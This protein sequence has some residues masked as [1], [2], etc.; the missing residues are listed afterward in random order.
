MVTKEQREIAMK[1]KGVLSN[2]GAAYFT[3]GKYNLAKEAL[4]RAFLVDP[5]SDYIHVY[6]VRTLLKLGKVK[7][8]KEFVD[9][10]EDNFG[11][12]DYI[13]RIKK[14]IEKHETKSEEKDSP[15]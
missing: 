3:V 8:A 12:A 1:M 5:K 2:L 13:E 7:D 9:F 6:T 11:G 14:Q 10:V 4:K 15:K